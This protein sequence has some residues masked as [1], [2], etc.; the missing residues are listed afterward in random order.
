MIIKLNFVDT[1][2]LY[3]RPLLSELQNLVLILDHA[4]GGPSHVI[5]P[6]EGGREEGVIS[7]I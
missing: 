6:G 1:E 3:N 7:V 4:L 2:H 5:G